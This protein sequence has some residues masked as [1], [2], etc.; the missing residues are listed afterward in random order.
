MMT[1]L[2][3]HRSVK[4]GKNEARVDDRTLQIGKYFLKSLALA[5]DNVDNTCGITDWGMML[6]GPNDGSTGAPREGLGDCTVAGCGH[7]EQVW[8]ACRGGEYT[9]PDTAILQ[10]YEQWDGYVLGDPS[11]DNG[12][13]ELTV[14]NKWRKG[15]FWGHPLLAHGNV[16]LNNL[17]EV[18]QAIYYFGFIYIG[19][20]LPIICQGQ[21]IWTPGQAND[22]NA[23]PGSWGGHCLV[24]GTKVL[25]NDLH[26]VGAETV[27]SGD[28]LFGFD[29]SRLPGR[30]SRKYRKAMVEGTRTFDLPCYELTFDDGTEVC[31]SYDH[32]WLVCNSD[33]IH[34]WVSTE[35]LR[36]GSERSSFILKPLETW[37]ED[38]SRDAGYL[39]AA[40]DGEGWL[41]GEKK[42]AI[43]KAGFCQRENEMLTRV[44]MALAE[45]N[46]HFSDR[47]HASG[48]TDKP[49]ANLIVNTSK[50]N[51]LKFLGSIRPH[52]LLSKFTADRCGFLQG[53]KVRLVKK[54]SCGIKTVVAIQTNSGTLMAE[55]LTSHNCVIIPKY[56][57]LPDGTLLFTVISWGGNYEMTQA[58]WTY[59][60]PDN[61]PYIDEAHAMVAPEFVSLKTGKT[62]EGLDLTTMESDLKLVAA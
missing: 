12:G 51:L 18:K 39:A 20:Q 15:S 52:R 50:A 21:N 22:P 11:T 19:V 33:G 10:K 37:K 27:K 57:T 17:T 44:R 2:E 59:N 61:G 3:F 62:P 31:C 8:S 43:H 7:G 54:E 34:H 42:R 32:L 56:V 53:R 28:A 14:L 36:M 9:P 47:P 5:P 24:P 48:F 26:W 25:T 55:G 41:D 4:L 38:V 23:I 46:V 13:D 60:D 1:L 30:K 40:F 35:Q 16:D 49:L 29:E 6:N 58:F 45:R